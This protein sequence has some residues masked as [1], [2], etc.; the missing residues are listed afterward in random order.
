MKHKA[1]LY[2][3][4]AVFFLVVGTLFLANKM[5]DDKGSPTEVQETKNKTQVVR[6]VV[7][8]EY[9]MYRNFEELVAHS[10]SVFNG[11]VA[12]YEDKLV[13]TKAKID[14][15]GLT[16]E[17]REAVSINQNTDDAIFPCRVFKVRVTEDFKGNHEVGD[18]VEVKQLHG[19]KNGL[20]YSE[21]GVVLLETG[22]EY[23]LFLQDYEGSP[24]SIVNPTQGM[25]VEENGA[26]VAPEQAETS[27]E[28]SE[29]KLEELEN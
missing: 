12:S 29:S 14:V 8:T 7:N 21:S 24:S 15:T 6:A 27:I 25:Y 28:V 10:D 23:L 11:E 9:P 22:N 13:D 17:E 2:T 26:Y 1:M 19:K 20:D 4:V 3:V 16:A 5:D 18:I